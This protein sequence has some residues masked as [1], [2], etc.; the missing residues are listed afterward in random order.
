MSELSTP[1]AVPAPGK[2]PVRMNL[3]RRILKR[4]LGVAAAA[5]LLLVAIIAII[6]PQLAPLDPNY[7]DIRNVLAAPGGPNLLGTDSSGRDVWSR[8]LAATQTSIAAALLA[9]VV[10]IV[11]GVISGLI[12]G[13]YQGW[14]NTVATWITELNM[15]LPGIVVLLAARADLGP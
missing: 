12:A 13:Y 10:A 11:I 3:F 6:G 8:L 1:L 2:A 7:V 15:A 9:V 5:F 14:F 4:P